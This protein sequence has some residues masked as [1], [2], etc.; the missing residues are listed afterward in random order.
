MILV[1]DFE[2]KKIFNLTSSKVVQKKE[3]KFFRNINQTLLF[4]E[5]IFQLVKIHN[6]SIKFIIEWANI[7]F[8][9]NKKI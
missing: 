6:V 3:Y 8:Y 4:C 2:E 9:T 7:R 5:V 1:R